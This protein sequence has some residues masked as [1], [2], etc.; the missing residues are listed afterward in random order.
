MYAE[1][2]ITLPGGFRLPVALV[3]E[4]VF[5]T[6]LQQAFH[7]PQDMQCRLE[8]FGERY[9]QGQMISGSVIGGETTFSE[10]DGLLVLEGE[11]LCT[12]MIGRLRQ[13][14]IGE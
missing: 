12:E 10:A 11:Y 8:K 9:V 6:E 2:Y 3:K 14:K 4:T 13:E 7:D 1:Y 5:V